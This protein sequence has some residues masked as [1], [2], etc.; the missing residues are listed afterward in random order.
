MWNEP[1][2][3]D[4]MPKPTTFARAFRA[5]DGEEI[6][7]TLGA[8]VDGNAPIIEARGMAGFYRPGNRAIRDAF[9]SRHTGW[10]YHKLNPD[11]STANYWINH[12]A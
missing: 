2:W 3:S 10:R 11:G 6:R 4:F 9:E 12:N 8:M 7:V 5:S 1:V